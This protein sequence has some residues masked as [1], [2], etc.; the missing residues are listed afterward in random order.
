MICK[1]IILI[2]LC[3]MIFV[4]CC[5]KK[6]EK[7]ITFS[8][9]G[10]PNEIEFW[11]KIIKEFEK[12]KNIKVNII[13]QPTDTDQRRQGLVIPLKSK[14][15]DPD[16]FLMDVAWIAQFSASG[17]LEEIDEYVKKGNLNLDVFF[18]K[19]LNLADKYNGK[20]IALPV[21]IDGGMLYYRK[22]LLQKYGYDVPKT[23]SE[24]VNYSLEIQKEIR[25]TN[26]N[27]YSFVWQ[28]AQ[29]EGL[30]CNFL[31]YAG[32]NNG[33]IIFK[34]GKILINTKE[35]IEAVK[36]MHNLINKYKISPPNTFTEMK[37]EEVRIFFQD[38]NA[39]FERNWPYAY[40]LHQSRD[41]K[42]KDKIGISPLPY[43]E[44]GESAST[45]GG[46]HIGISKFSDVKDKSFEFVKFI[47]SYETQKKF[48]LEL[49]WNPGRKDLY[50]DKD[51]LDKLPHFSELKD[52]FENALPRPNL[53]YY[54]QI[55]EVLQ[56]YINSALANKISPDEALSSAEKEIQ[57]TV[58]RY[59]Q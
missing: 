31:E 3:L 44:G 11:E 42:I 22:D 15:D 16:V 5:A 45:L 51:I 49:A 54:T 26:P 46:W 17:W 18:S 55:S 47:T 4:I 59:T 12:E 29:Y 40:A 56:K 48:A 9:G 21:Y 25:K 33:G 24:L 1:K 14:K 27:F 20:L 53:P 6:E 34:D 38:G 58:E 57:V 50:N 19:V 52:V 36:F 30:I 7:F 37:E 23:W 35:N 2:I 8:V 28:G 43:F 32:S 39:L 41:S 13:R 10:A